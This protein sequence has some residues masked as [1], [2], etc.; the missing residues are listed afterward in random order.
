MQFVECNSNSISTQFTVN[1]QVLWFPFRVGHKWDLRKGF[2]KKPRPKPKSPTMN[3]KH[4][5]DTQ[6]STI[7]IIFISFYWSDVIG[8]HFAI[9]LMMFGTFHFNEYSNWIKMSDKRKVSNNVRHWW[10]EIWVTRQI[11]SFVSL[12]TCI[13]PSCTGSARLHWI[14]NF[15]L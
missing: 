2:C 13:L 3:L 7:S 11:A 8:I 4:R 5:C 1:G 9:A 10:V 15:V 14:I 12:T 6:K